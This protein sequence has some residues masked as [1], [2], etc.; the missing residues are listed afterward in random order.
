[1]SD[2]ASLAAS[3]KAEGTQFFKAGDYGAAASLFARAIALGGD[4]P[5]ALHANAAA[6]YAAMND[7][8]RALGSADAA[9][10]ANPS[11]MKAHYRRALALSGLERWSEAAVACHSALQL[12]ATGGA[13]EQISQLLKKCDAEAANA[14]PVPAAMPPVLPTAP[15]QRTPPTAAEV[16]SEM[17]RR[18]AAAA[19]AAAALEEQS[20][21]RKEKAESDRK[22]REA[23][24]AAR[25]AALDE[26]RLG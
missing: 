22:Q 7:H 20:R 21:L 15:A 24:E 8:A 16:A 14:P 5:H 13:A 19:A 17:E 6:C 4:E 23:T 12:G 25:V 26:V 2:N 11:F 9:V 3:A 18:K 1:M 10:A